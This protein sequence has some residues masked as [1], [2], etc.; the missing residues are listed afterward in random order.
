MNK[1]RSRAIQKHRAK[2]LNFE[3]RRKMEAGGSAPPRPRQQSAG[4]S[5]ITSGSEEQPAQ[6]AQ[7][8]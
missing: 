4:G 5:R 7:E 1:T 8:S 3:M 6:D 2:G